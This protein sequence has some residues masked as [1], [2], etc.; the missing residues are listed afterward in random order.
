MH[1]SGANYG[2]DNRETKWSYYFSKY[3][4][5]WGWATWRRAW[6]YYDPEIKK[7]PELLKLNQFP[8]Y[9]NNPSEL[10]LKMNQYD[11]LYANEID[12]WDYQW[13]LAKYTQN[14]L[15][16]IP[17]VNLVENIG[18]DEMATHTKTD[19][20]NFSK[21]GSEAIGQ[22]NHP[23]FIIRNAAFDR[24]VS[25]PVVEQRKGWIIRLY[26]GMKKFVQ[27]IT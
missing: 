7:Y 4:L 22:I 9:Y 19:P 10:E 12:T 8:F 3:G 13:S 15:S 18:F 26:T 11:R 21:I 27:L 24:Y 1:I 6:N 23:E 20:N 2:I 25:G 16:I 14:G 17:H 5:V